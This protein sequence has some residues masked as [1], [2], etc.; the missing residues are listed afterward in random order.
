MQENRIKNSKRN[1]IAGVLNKMVAMLFPFIIRTIMIKMIGVEYLGLNS[2]FTSVLS[3]LSITE[4]GFGTSM[5]YNMY[6]PIAE[7]DTDTVCALLNLYKKIYRIVGCVILGLG[8]VIMPFIKYFISGSYP[9]DINIYI[10]Y[11][12]FLKK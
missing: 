3:M 8:L 9:S 12:W 4:L 7:N 11:L 1:L 6:K 2:L 10:L 5:V